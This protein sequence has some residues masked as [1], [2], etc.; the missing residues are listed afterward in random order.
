MTDKTE[1]EIR[2]GEHAAS[3]LNDE[4]LSEAFAYVAQELTEQWQNSPAR[5]QSGREKLWLSLKLLQ[6]VHGHL[7]SVL[8]TGKFAKATLAQQ[9]GERLR[10]SL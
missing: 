9:I 3:L 5:D 6:K 2:R 8:E 10:Q 1:I 7:S 4:L